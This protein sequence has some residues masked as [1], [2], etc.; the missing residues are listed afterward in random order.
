MKYYKCP[1]CG[2]VWSSSDLYCSEGACLNYGSP[3]PEDECFWED[4]LEEIT[5]LIT[6]YTADLPV[7][8]DCDGC[9]QK[10]YGE[11]EGCENNPAN[12]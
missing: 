3:Y 9:E 6:T 12:H 1:G 10:N 11:C 8:S 5:H 2:S 7:G 4:E